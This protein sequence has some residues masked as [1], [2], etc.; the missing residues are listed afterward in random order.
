M[1]VKSRIPPLSRSAFACSLPRVL[2]TPAGVEQCGD[3]EHQADDR[4]QPAEEDVLDLAFEVERD[5][6]EER[7]LELAEMIGE[8][9][10][11]TAVARAERAEA[12]GRGSERET[13]DLVTA[14]ACGPSAAWPPAPAP[15]CAP[16]C[17]SP[18]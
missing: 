10:L 8:M 14:R 18:A 13:F 12:L 5:A 17:W 4:F 16:C 7:W 11:A 6:A 1:A 9:G 15:P 2:I 3:E